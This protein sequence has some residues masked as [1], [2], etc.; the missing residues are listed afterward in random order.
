[1]GK[2]DL[3]LALAK[4]LGAEIVSCDSRQVFRGLDIGTAKPTDAERRRVRHH[5]IDELDLDQAWT[6]GMFAREAEARIVDI[7]ERGRVPLIV[8]G[9]TLYLEALVHGMAEVPAA[10]A[11]IRATVTAEASTEAGRKRLLDE[12]RSGDPATAAV[13]DAAN[14]HRLARAVEVLRATGRPISSY[15]AAPARP[16][17]RYDVEVLT[18]ERSDIFRRIDARVDA[19]LQ[20]GLVEENRRLLDT[21]VD[22]DT[23]ALRAIG[24]REPMSYLMGEIDLEEMIRRLKMNTRRYARRQ[25]TW[26]RRH[27][28]YR[29]RELAP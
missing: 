22:R 19:M 21:G 14:P 25:L 18:R 27:P 7:L 8:G 26:F 5:F 29:W 1:V 23:A 28:E 16:A 3:S 9:S 6:A 4:S 10:P 13:I 24:Y 11:S 12:L 20:A 15:R 17:F 2:T